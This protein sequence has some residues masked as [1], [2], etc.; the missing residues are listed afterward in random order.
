MNT[1]RIVNH[2]THIV[3][4]VWPRFP[5]RLARDSL[6]IPDRPDLDRLDAFL[7]DPDRPEGTLSLMELH[8]LLFALQAA[9]EIVPPSEMLPLA[10]GGDSPGFDS[11]DEAQEILS[12]I[13]ALSNRINDGIVRREPELPEGCTI[14]EDPLANLDP[15]S[16]LSQWSRGFKVGYH[17]VNEDW[18]AWIP[19][20]EDH[21]DDPRDELS[22]ELGA[23]VMILTLFAS[24][25]LAER[26]RDA[27]ARD[28][29]SLEQVA[30]L[31]AQS[32][33]GAMRSYAVLGRS[34]HEVRLE[35]EGAE[36]RRREGLRAVGRN[37]PCSCGSG[38]KMKKCC[39]KGV[40]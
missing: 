33:T 35:T 24:R 1:A 37:D 22:H 27:F 9:P 18:A 7:S 28:D 10:F 5:T 40:G 39:G 13:I 19:D 31:S 38:K 6:M 32:F 29:T 2:H 11:V 20:P 15:S 25:G 26:F 8:G 17:Y 4:C 36:A 16:S 14:L 30:E 12:A 34:I 23:T 21:P 3:P